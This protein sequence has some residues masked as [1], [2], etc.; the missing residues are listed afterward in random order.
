VKRSIVHKISAGERG[1][2]VDSASARHVFLVRSFLISLAILFGVSNP[3]GA[4]DAGESLPAAEHVFGPG[5]VRVTLTRDGRWLEFMPKWNGNQ[6]LFSQGGVMVF[7]KDSDGRLREIVNGLEAGIRVGEHGSKIRVC[8]EGVKG[9]FRAPSPEPDDDRDGR[10]NEDR[11]DGIDND[12]DGKI[13]EDFAA[14]GDEMATT[15]YFA[16]GTEESGAQLAFHQEAY[17][18]SLPH[19]DGTIMVSLWVKNIGSERLDDVRIGAL[20]EKDGPF[21]FSNWVVSLPGEPDAQHSNVVVCEDLQGTDMGIVVFPEDGIDGGSWLGGVLENT[22]KASLILADR[23]SNSPAGSPLGTRASPFADSSRDASLVKTKE[24]RVDGRTRV[25]LA[26]PN[27]G[28]LPSGEEIRVDL[29]FFAVR[30]RTE[31]E[32]AAINAFKTFA[33]DGVNRHLPPP[34]SMTPRVIWG[35]YAPIKNDDE[36]AR[37]VA[38]EFETL[39]DDPV[40]T[41]EIS[42]FSGLEPD[43]VER[44]ELEPGVERV[45]LRGDIVATAVQKRERIILKGRLENGE[46]FEAI[47]KP[48]EGEAGTADV[49]DDAELFW[50]TEGRLDLELLSSSPNPFR[51]ATTIYYEIPGLIEQSDGTR[52][53][54]RESL[55]VS[56]KVYN[57][58]GRLVGVLV[59]DVLPPGAYATQ[60]RGMDDQ[61]NEVASGVYYVRLQIGKKYLTQRLILLK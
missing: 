33:G 41:D 5:K 55:K 53:E 6:P 54:S 25:Y 14:V 45:V 43:A 12:A 42:S 30:E 9:G 13:D 4:T 46:F 50:K 59:E 18:W 34:V 27:L 17:A 37:R 16:P 3:S 19:I 11:L 22:E 32:T 49:G 8:T 1:S 26:S 35:S 52:I 24:I 48:Q 20:V 38:I 61:G 57:V 36:G 23:L 7:A 29:A 60:W 56:V 15:C 40:T 31:V 10:V 47:L 39:G 2:S 44:V 21:Y 28:S 58:V 51:D